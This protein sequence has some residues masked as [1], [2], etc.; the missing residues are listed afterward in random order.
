MP[1]VPCPNC[2][3]KGWF[4]M[5]T[6]GK[7]VMSSHCFKCHGLGMV[8]QDEQEPQRFVRALRSSLAV[9]VLLLPVVGCASKKSSD[10]IDWAKIGAVMEAT[11]SAWSAP[12][13]SYQQQWWSNYY[14][15]QAANAQLYQADLARKQHLQ[16]FR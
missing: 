5:I 11:G 4:D 2:N 16:S 10:E 13:P 6:D 15:Q 7:S 12:A 3:G 8:W 9:L 14:A 1:M